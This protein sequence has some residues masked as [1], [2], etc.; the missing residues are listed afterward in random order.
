MSSP[1]RAE[2]FGD[3]MQWYSHATVDIVDVYR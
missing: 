1:E 2:I 3:R